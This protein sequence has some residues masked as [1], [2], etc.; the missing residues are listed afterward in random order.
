MQLLAMISMLLDHIGVVF[1]PNDPIW[2]ILGRL[3]LPL[4]LYG[5]VQGWSRTRSRARYVRRLAMI[6]AAAQIPFMLVGGAKVNVIGTF[7]V[8]LAV[9]WVI[10]N[11]ASKRLIIFSAIIGAVVMLELIPFDYGSYALFLAL[12][13]RYL[14]ASTLVLAHAGL[15]F[16]AAILLGWQLQIYSILATLLLVSQSRL[17]ARPS[18]DIIPRWLWLS[19]YPLHLLVIAIFSVIPMLD[20]A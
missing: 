8:V 1:F 6:G 13:Y 2:R 10:D 18:R 15:D 5:I 16:S 19:F 11:F 3:A 17:V 12:A 14:N 4:Y 20:Q 9:L 7:L